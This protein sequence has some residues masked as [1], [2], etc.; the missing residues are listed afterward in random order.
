MNMGR[1]VGPVAAWLMRPPGWPM[2]LF[3]SAAVLVSLWACVAPT[4]RGAFSDILS[5]P[6]FLVPPA[7]WLRR[8]RGF[9]WE[10][11]LPHGRFMLGAALWAV[12]IVAW[13]IRRVARG[14]TVR[15][16]SSHRAA[17][18]AYWRRWLVVPV[19]FGLTVLVCMTRLPTYAGFWV[20]KPWLERSVR[21]A[22]GNPARGLPGRV[23][24]A[25]P[26]NPGSP[27]R[28]RNGTAWF[29]VVS[30]EG[31]THVLIGYG[32]TLVRQDD[33]RPPTGDIR[34]VS[35]PVRARRL[36]SHWFLVETE[37]TSD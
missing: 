8:V 24:G 11:D 21:E 18:F 2:Y 20:S 31:R 30:T 15:R 33:G 12:L 25:F 27:M 35:P 4:R 14:V 22:K 23:I 6:L 29:Q 1:E 16:L 13:L 19:V 7:L 26:P 5:E 37:G 17:P 34:G 9:W 32:A 3:L 28:T 10:L 36:S